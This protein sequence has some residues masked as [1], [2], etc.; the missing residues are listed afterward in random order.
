[1]YYNS[2]G[3]TY[4]VLLTCFILSLVSYKT[5]V[6]ATR[7]MMPPITVDFIRVL[8]YVQYYCVGNYVCCYATVFHACMK[9]TWQPA[10]SCFIFASIS[11]CC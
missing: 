4:A 5:D 10:V 2:S 9:G 8:T 6:H 7:L 1:M 3:Y 11:T